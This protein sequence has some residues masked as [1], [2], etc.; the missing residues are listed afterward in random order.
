MAEQVPVKGL[1]VAQVPQK[2]LIFPCVI[3][4][5][6]KRVWFCLPTGQEFI[7]LGLETDVLKRLYDVV[8]CLVLVALQTVLGQC[9]EKNDCHLAIQLSNLLGS[10]QTIHSAHL[11]IQEMCIRDRPGFF[12]RLR[13]YDDFPAGAVQPFAVAVPLWR[14]LGGVPSVRSKPRQGYFWLHGL[15]WAKALLAAAGG[16]SSGKRSWLVFPPT[17]PGPCS[18]CL[19]GYRQC[20]RGRDGLFQHGGEDVYKRQIWA[21]MWSRA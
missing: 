17:L 20:N 8:G 13:Q 19:F 21:R 5:E 12:R 7:H 6:Q 3:D 10:P 15:L 1:D 4:D 16:L 11:N 2:Y 18:A 9:G 14:A